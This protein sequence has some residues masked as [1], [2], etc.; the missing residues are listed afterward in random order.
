MANLEWT[1]GGK[2]SARRWYRAQRSVAVYVFAGWCLVPL[3]WLLEVSLRPGLTAFASGPLKPF[4]PTASNYVNVFET[5]G[6]GGGLERSALVV[7]ASTAI[8]VLLAVPVAYVLTHV[9][10]PNSRKVSRVTLFFLASTIAPQI[11]VI[12]P[13]FQLFTAVGLMGSLVG[14]GL[15]YSIMNISL[16]VLLLRS[17]FSA[18]PAEVR[19]AGLTDGGGE[20]RVMLSC[21]VPIARGGLIATAILCVLQTWN[22]FLY[23]LVIV[24]GNHQTLPIVITSFLTFEGINWGQLAAASIIAVVPI[25]MFSLLVQKDLSRGIS[26]G[27]VKQ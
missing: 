14:L 27:A 25:V 2:T 17:Y 26:F 5:G 11:V 19:E 3:L 15:L 16:A 12:L 24:G 8:G 13:I 21:V 22:E 1:P 4:V 20:W 18:V 7:G 6:V 23:A 10:D 9:W